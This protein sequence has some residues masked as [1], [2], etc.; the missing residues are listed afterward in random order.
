M[1]R[2]LF[3][4]HAA[5]INDEGSFHLSAFRRDMRAEMDEV[6]SA[7]GISQA[8]QAAEAMRNQQIQIVVTSDMKRAA[9]TGQII[10]E[11]LA[12]QCIV[13]P[14]LREIAPGEAPGRAGRLVLP[15]LDRRL[16]RFVRRTAGQLLAAYLSLRYIWSWRRGLNRDGETIEKVRARVEAAL[17]AL[18]QRPELTILVVGHGFWILFLALMLTKPHRRLNLRWV[19]NCSVTEI[20]TDEQGNRKLLYFARPAGDAQAAINNA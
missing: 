20:T 19:K 3:M 10:A 8:V 14:G 9:Q 18:D 11:E 16:P 7:R 13:L 15:L 6:L 17:S 2:Y 1:R 4:R 12:A 5:P